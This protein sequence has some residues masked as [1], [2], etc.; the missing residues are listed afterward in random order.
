MKNNES[1]S[2][3]SEGVSETQNEIYKRLGCLAR[4]LHENLSDLGLGN[5]FET[6]KQELPTI[7]NQLSYVE[8]LSKDAAE[9]VLNATD[10]AIPVQTRL[11]RQLDDLNKEW[12]GLL[13]KK[14][15]RS[16]Y[17][18]SVS[19]I[20]AFLELTNKEALKTKEQLLE[21]M[22]A[23]DFQ[24][25]TGQIIKKIMLSLVNIETQLIKLLVD[26]KNNFDKG[27]KLNSNE[28]KQSKN[29]NFESQKEVDDFLSN[30]G[31]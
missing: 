25:L 22:M 3:N 4:E 13:S 31:F 20:L 5:I 29:N 6:V 11:V 24:D 9:K 7:N 14:S 23:Q 27:Y 21:I 30:L 10:E 2:L 8:K 16:E 26:S 18:Q 17:N 19:K 1:V 12:D 15:L 28:T